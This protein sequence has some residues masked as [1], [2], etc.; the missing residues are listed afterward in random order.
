MTICKLE[1]QRTTYIIA[2]F[3]VKVKQ[4]RLKTIYFNAFVGFLGYTV[5]NNPS[6]T[7]KRVCVINVCV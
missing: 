1:Y 4:I 5:T 6:W 3:T 2:H 7:H